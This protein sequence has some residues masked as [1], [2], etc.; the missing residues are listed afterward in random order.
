[1]AFAVPWIAA[2]GAT[3]VT[4]TWVQPLL[5][6]APDGFWVQVAAGVVAVLGVLLAA[7]QRVDAWAR[8]MACVWMVSMLWIGVVIPW[9][10]QV[11][12]APFQEVATWAREHQPQA[13]VVQ[14]RM[15]QP[16]FAFYL[17]APTTQQAP[18]DRDWVIVRQDRIEGLAMNR[19]EIAHAHRGL[20]LLKPI[21][22]T[23]P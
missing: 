6:S 22:A 12:Q 7:S 21:A 9:L 16:S 8:L 4:D 14:W 17:G 11:L 23:T 3:T 19:Y 15:H 10:G 20:L 2:W 13:R 18:N 5:A 1:L